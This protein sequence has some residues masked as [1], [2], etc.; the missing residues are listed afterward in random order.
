MAEK[1]HIDITGSEPE[2]DT[3]DIESFG[4][5]PAS[6]PPWASEYDEEETKKKRT[7]KTKSVQFERDVREIERGLYSKANVG[8]TIYLLNH[9]APFTAPVNSI[10]LSIGD[11]FMDRE[12][13]SMACLPV[14]PVA[15]RSMSL[16]LNTSKWRVRN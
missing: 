8:A 14:V 7:K 11:D 2:R 15:I 3:D 5:P 13:L 9:P 1:F 4:S 10:A 16:R 12:S 6:I